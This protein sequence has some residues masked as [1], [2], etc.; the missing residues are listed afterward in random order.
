MRDKTEPDIC[1]L[2]LQNADY[3]TGEVSLEVTAADYDCPMMYYDYST[4]GGRTYSELLPWPGLDIMAGTYPDTF[5]F[6]VT[7]TKG[8]QPVITSAVTIRRI[9]SQRVI[10]SPL[11]SLLLIRKKLPKRHYRKVLRHRR[12]RKLPGL[13]R[14]RSQKLAVP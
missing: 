13:Q 11:R 14:N 12:Q 8:E 10:L 2:T 4:D 6:S 3:E 1:Q 7:F 9:C 5:T